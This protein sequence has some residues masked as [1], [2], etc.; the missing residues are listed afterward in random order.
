[1]AD[2]LIRNIDPQLKRQLRARA[3]KHQRSMSEE[4]RVLLTLFIP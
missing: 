3:R 1:M 2:L 4:A